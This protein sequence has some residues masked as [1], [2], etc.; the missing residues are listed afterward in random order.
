MAPGT[1]AALAK[2]T[3]LP[4]CSHFRASIRDPGAP[5]YPPSSS[6]E[7]TDSDGRAGSFCCVVCPSESTQGSRTPCLTTRGIG[8]TNT[9]QLQRKP[10]SCEPIYPKILLGCKQPIRSRNPS[11]RGP[12]TLPCEWGPRIPLT[13]IVDPPSPWHLRDETPLPVHPIGELKRRKTM[14]KMRRTA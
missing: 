13:M 12:R 2:T 8:P 11:M 14:R 3:L 6:K 10:C 5:L 1:M 4:P 9:S 7:P